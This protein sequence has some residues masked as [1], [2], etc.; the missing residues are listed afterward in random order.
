MNFQ[1]AIKTCLK[2]KYF[3]FQGRASRSEY[4]LFYLFTSIFYSL[5]IPACT[6][7]FAFVVFFAITPA[8]SFI[9]LATVF[10]SLLIP[11]LAVAARRL[12]DI[13]RSG[14]W[15]LIVLIPILGMVIFFVFTTKKGTEGENRFGPPVVDTE[16]IIDLLSI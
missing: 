5:L 12:H 14:W 6:I 15:Q 9:A 10:L 3:R 16:E 11:T 13:D 1:T 8:L 7:F 2:K 4:W